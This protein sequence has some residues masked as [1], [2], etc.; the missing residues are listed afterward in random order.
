MTSLEHKYKKL[1]LTIVRIVKV[2]PKKNSCC[3][4]SQFTCP[5]KTV[6]FTGSFQAALF[7]FADDLLSSKGFHLAESRFFCLSQ[8]KK[9]NR[10]KRTAEKNHFFETC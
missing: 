7:S 9:K 3:T 1:L 6:L 8:Q 2:S 10:S 5:K 4:I